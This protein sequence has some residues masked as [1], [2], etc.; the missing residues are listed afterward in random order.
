VYPQSCVVHHL[1][2]FETEYKHVL[3]DYI[4]LHPLRHRSNSAP[5][6]AFEKIRIRNCI[7]VISAP[8]HIRQKKCGWGCGKGIIRSDPLSFQHRGPAEAS[9]CAC[10]PVLV[11]QI[12]D[13]ESSSIRH[14]NLVSSSLLGQG[15]WATQS[16]QKPWVSLACREAA[17]NQLSFF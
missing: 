14:Q 4:N 7:H 10:G 9:W 16:T 17:E 11:A 8:L 15:V 6:L 2:P 13:V 1:S 3:S 12:K 5:Y